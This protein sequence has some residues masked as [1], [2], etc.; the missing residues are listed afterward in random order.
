M[1]S[2]RAI[3][4]SL[5]RLRSPSATFSK[6]DSHIKLVSDEVEF[7]S[8]VYISLATAKFPVNIACR[9][10]R[11]L[12]HFPRDEIDLIGARLVSEESCLFA[13][14]CVLRQDKILAIICFFTSLFVTTLNF[15][16]S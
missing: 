9:D 7:I 10:I 4:A 8:S 16:K 12:S 15:S 13:K 5:Q 3:E 1:H 6:A 11:Y 14:K 2:G